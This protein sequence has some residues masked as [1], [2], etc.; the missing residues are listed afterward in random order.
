M[1]LCSSW[2][3]I[4]LTSQV[5]ISGKTTNKIAAATIEIQ[6]GVTPLNMVISG[7]PLATPAV[8]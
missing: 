7:T 1:P 8:T 5:A 4:K 6:N 2:I 3:Y